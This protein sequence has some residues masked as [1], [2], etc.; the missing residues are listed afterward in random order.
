MPEI[1]R[2]VVVTFNAVAIPLAASVLLPVVPAQA[3]LIVSVVIA[4]V[5]TPPAF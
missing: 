1:I 4:I 3:N 5:I 2:S